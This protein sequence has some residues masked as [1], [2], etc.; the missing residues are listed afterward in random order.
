MARIGPG[1]RRS[2][3]AAAAAAAGG[4]DPLGLA[5]LTTMAT[6]PTD[7]EHESRWGK[8]TPGSADVPSRLVV[9]K[10][11]D[12]DPAALVM[13]VNLGGGGSDGNSQGRRSSLRAGVARG[14]GRTQ[15]A[16]RRVVPS[17]TVDALIDVDPDTIARVAAAS[18]LA[19][20]GGR[21]RR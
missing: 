18:A 20:R 9:A 8:G 12:P 19:K 7:S 3:P 4:P 14:A 6:S 16:R 15:P 11:S 21:R 13:H 17:R 2:S 5:L 1:S 10:K